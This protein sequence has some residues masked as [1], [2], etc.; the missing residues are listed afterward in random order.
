[1]DLRSRPSNLPPTTP[2]LFVILLH[3]YLNVSE[4]EWYIHIWILQISGIT[5]NCSV[6]Q[7][8]HSNWS[9]RRLTTLSGSLILQLLYKK[10]FFAQINDAEVTAVENGAVML[11]ENNQ[12][13][14]FNNR[15]VALP[16][17]WR[18]GVYSTGYRRSWWSVYIIFYCDSLQISSWLAS[19][20]YAIPNSVILNLI[21][22]PNIS[23]TYD[24]NG[25]PMAQAYSVSSAA[26]PNLPPPQ[27]NPVPQ[28]NPP[29]LLL[30]P[31]PAP[32]PNPAQVS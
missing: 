14:A 7:V 5:E 9:L 10:N 8:L 20:F 27:P 29:H 22:T 11:S 18:C 15:I 4:G 21:P 19:C 6:F 24:P 3:S 12:E 1:M 25:I 2:D 13:R 17:A 16:K 31:N 26:M 28:P 32:Q 23:G 30:H